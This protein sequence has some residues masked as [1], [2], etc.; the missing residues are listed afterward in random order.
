MYSDEQF[1][2]NFRVSRATFNML[3]QS[4]CSLAKEDTNMRKSIS[5]DKRI[6]VALYAIGSSSEYRTIGNL[7]GIGRTTVGE[8]VND[9]CEAV[10]YTFQPQF[11]N[12]LPALQ[13]KVTEI[14]NGFESEWGFPQCF[15][16][17]GKLFLLFEV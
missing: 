6:A 5:L 8:L 16:A 14:V 12:T 13:E 1:R 15:G 11:L 7:F 17:V 3:R 2:K 9:F 10:W 4:L